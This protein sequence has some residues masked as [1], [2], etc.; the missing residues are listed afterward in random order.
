LN[1]AKRENFEGIPISFKSSSRN[2][3]NI[4]TMAPKT[5]IWLNL[6]KNPL[7]WIQV[8]NNTKTRGGSGREEVAFYTF[9]KAS[10]FL[11]IPRVFLE[12]FASY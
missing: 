11:L 6:A 7:I 4:S 12:L 1:K 3:S 10:L 9:L 2:N 5:K 8:A